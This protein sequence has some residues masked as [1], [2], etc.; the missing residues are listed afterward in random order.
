MILRANGKNK[1]RRNTDRE[2]KVQPTSYKGHTLYDATVSPGKAKQLY[3]Q[4]I[5]V[6]SHEFGFGI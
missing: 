5:A 1:E 6:S 2:R 3:N 4:Q